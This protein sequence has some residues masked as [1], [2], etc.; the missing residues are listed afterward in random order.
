[1]TARGPATTRP[2]PTSVATVAVLLVLPAF[3]GCITVDPDTPGN[4]RPQATPPAHVCRAVQVPS[5]R[6]GATYAWGAVGRYY[7]STRWVN[8]DWSATNPDSNRSD[9]IRLP[10][11]SSLTIRIADDPEPMLTYRGDHVPAIQATYWFD[12]ADEENPVPAFDVWLD[13]DN[14]TLVQ[15]AWRNYVVADD[16][17]PFHISRFLVASRPPLLF[18]SLFWNATLA[19]NDDGRYVWGEGPYGFLQDGFGPSEWINWTIERVRPAEGRDACLA[20]VEAEVGLRPGTQ[21]GVAGLSLTL[22]SDRALPVAYTWDHPEVWEETFGDPFPTFRLAMTD[23]TPGTGP[24]LSPF[25]DP[26]PGEDTVDDLDATRLEMRPPRNGSN[27][28]GADL[29]ATDYDQAVRKARATED[30]R[31]WFDD[32][33]DARPAFYQHLKGNASSPV[34]D[35]WNIFWSEPGGPDTFQAQITR[36]EPLAPVLDDRFDV[37]TQRSQRDWNLTPLEHWTTMGGFEQAF[38]SHYD[39]EELEV[40][41]CDFILEETDVK[42]TGGSQNSTGRHDIGTW[43]GIV[44]FTI[45][46]DEGWIF[47]DAGWTVGDEPF[48]PPVR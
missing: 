26:W 34:I 16:G 12:H 40:L 45:W 48:G 3:V 21:L 6:Q 1:M 29:F 35:H 44:P 14:G 30:G 10:S 9:S 39:G 25:E 11:G 22:A 18:G 19:A 33:P 31:A 36:K 24:R 8:T 7:E 4:G 2:R 42:C 15:E 23:A 46:I 38:E 17:D 43:A 20:D 37:H 41:S 5:L 32:H 27:Y 13:P 28:H 47:S